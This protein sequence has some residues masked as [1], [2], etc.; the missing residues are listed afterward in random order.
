VTSW[1]TASKWAVAAM[2]VAVMTAGDVS[3]VGMDSTTVGAE[4]TVAVVPVAMRSVVVV[5]RGVLGGVN[6]SFANVGVPT[7]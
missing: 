1:K 7:V 5:P 3:G 2:A 4:G 6:V